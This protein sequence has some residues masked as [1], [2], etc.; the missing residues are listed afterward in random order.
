MKTSQIVS[1]QLQVRL[2]PKGSSS[3]TVWWS[4][5]RKLTG[6]RVS[7]SDDSHITT[8]GWLRSRRHIMRVSRTDASAKSESPMNCHPGMASMTIRPSSSQASRNA[9][10]G[11]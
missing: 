3:F 10:A 6:M 1:I 4:L 5:A 8:D 11:G 9:G 7:F 2:L